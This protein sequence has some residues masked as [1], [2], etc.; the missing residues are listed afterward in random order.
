[1][2]RDFQAVLFDFDYT[3]ADSSRPVFE[4][5]NFALAGMGL[6]EASYENVCR[7]IGLSLPDALARLA[8]EDH[9]HLSDGF[10]KLFLEMADQVMVE[11]TVL[12]DKVPETMT[13]LKDQG[14]AL[15]IVSTKYRYRIESILARYNS[16]DIFDVI[17]GGEDVQEHKPHPG[18]LLAALQKLDAVVSSSLYVGDSVVDAETAERANVG[19]IATLTGV[20]AEKDFN[21]Y[22]SQGTIKHVSELPGFI[23]CLRLG[24]GLRSIDFRNNVKWTR[25]AR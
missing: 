11:K 6:P 8:G 15:G 5:I 23:S 25:H 22:P 24:N 16:R 7:T 9:R 17:I 21:G 1:M 19:F 12:F 14:L 4:C 18:G 3:L 10:L 2:N 20:T 13:K